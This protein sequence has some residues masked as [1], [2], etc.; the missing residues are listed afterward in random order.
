MEVPGRQAARFL[1]PFPSPFSLF[2]FLPAGQDADTR[3]ELFPP[4]PI[5]FP[6]YLF[7]FFFSFH[8]RDRA[9]RKGGIG[10]ARVAIVMMLL[11][12]SLNPSFSFSL[13]GVGETEVL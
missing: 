2:F 12:G 11:F 4:S 3:P 8:Q 10:R 13:F 7:L 6:S 1:P 9:Q 5:L